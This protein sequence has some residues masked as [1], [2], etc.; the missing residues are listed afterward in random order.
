VIDLKRFDAP[1]GAAFATGRVWGDY[2]DG[3]KDRKAEPQLCPRHS[4]R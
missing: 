3:S 4:P 2:Q 1:S